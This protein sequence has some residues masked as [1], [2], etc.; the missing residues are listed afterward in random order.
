MALT[1]PMLSVKFCANESERG[2]AGWI[3]VQFDK[4]KGVTGMLGWC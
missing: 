3:S 2:F 4:L 1:L